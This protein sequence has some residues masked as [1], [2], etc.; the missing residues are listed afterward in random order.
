[1]RLQVATTAYN[2]KR[3]GKPWI[4]RVVDEQLSFRFGKFV[5]DEGYAG[6]LVLDVEAGDVI[7]RGQKDNRNQR[8]QEPP[9]YFVVNA[10]LSLTSISKVDAYKILSNK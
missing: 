8:A 4:A 3:Y 9:A 7:A 2:E 5:G 1:M 6:L 10:D